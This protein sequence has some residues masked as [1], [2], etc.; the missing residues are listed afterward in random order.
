[1][2]SADDSNEFRSRL[3]GLYRETGPQ[4]LAWFQR[5]HRS[6]HAAEDL[7]HET[8][9]AVMRH[10]ERLLQSASPRAYLFG[11]ARN[12]SIEAYREAGPVLE[13]VTELPVEESGGTD[14]RLDDMRTAI[15]KLNPA[16]REV[17]ELRLQAEFSYDEIAS[18]L[19]IPIGT[20]RSRLHHA[21]KQLRE[22]LNRHA[23]GQR[24]ESHYE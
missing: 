2:S 4:L 9:A 24:V 15:A 20:V 11:V 12:L 1:L 16:L 10:P 3:G 7:L 6:P 8:F 13:M 17:L 14:A 5:R 22:A 18:V 23:K 21:V 19:E